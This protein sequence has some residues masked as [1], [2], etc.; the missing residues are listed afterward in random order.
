MK[1]DILNF[2]ATKKARYLSPRWSLVL[3]APDKG[4]TLMQQSL[5]SVLI[6]K[7]G[8]IATVK[9]MHT[10]RRR[11]RVSTMILLQFVTLILQ[12][13]LSRDS[14]VCTHT[15]ILPV[16][17]ASFVTMWSITRF[18]GHLP[19]YYKRMASIV[20]QIVVVLGNRKLSGGS[21]NWPW[22]RRRNLL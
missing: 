10:L 12:N 15:W 14:V 6:F 13:I 17:K 1:Q 16:R 11:E 19:R 3:V 7:M 22:V 9:F 18:C 8:K 20:S 4:F 5:N 2:Y 21:V